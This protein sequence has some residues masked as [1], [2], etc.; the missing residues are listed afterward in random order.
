VAYGSTARAARAAVDELRA[1]GV[2]AGL[3]ELQ[4]LWPFPKALIASIAGQVEGILVPEVNLGQV[5][6]Y[7]E[8]AA[9][10][11]APVVPLNRADGKLFRPD[12]IAAALR[13]MTGSKP[14]GRGRAP[15]VR[16][17]AAA[18]GSREA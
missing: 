2:R 10:G 15:V 6:W 5:V 11:Q 14:S 1:E 3:V 17:A 16:E 12:Q 8:A 9:A 4:T 7:V 18:A 13:P